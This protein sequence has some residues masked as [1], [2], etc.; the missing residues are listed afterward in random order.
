MIALTSEV[1]LQDAKEL[2]A[3]SD[4]IR[5]ELGDRAAGVRDALA[6][7]APAIPRRHRVALHPRVGLL[8]REPLLRQREQQRAADG[9][10][11]A[12]DDQPSPD[13]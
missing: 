11:I 2:L 6:Q 3:L 8:A 4:R 10:Q 5:R 13:H 9:Q 7:L 12:G 1:E